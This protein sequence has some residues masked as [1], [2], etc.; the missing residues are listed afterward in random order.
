MEQAAQREGITIAEAEANFLQR[1]ALRR[2]ATAD[3]VARH[4]VFL[5]SEAAQHMSGTSM[6]VDGG[7]TYAP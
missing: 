5:A 2:L 3:E 6:T 4:V 7:S 1:A